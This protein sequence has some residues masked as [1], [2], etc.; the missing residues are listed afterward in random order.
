[1]C[2]ICHL[3]LD[4]FFASVEERDKE[5][6][7]GKPIVVGAD[8]NE[9]KGRGVVSTAN[10][11]AREYG[12]H[13]AMPIS[14]AWQLSETARKKGYPPAEFLGVDFARYSE[15]SERVMEII[16]KYSSK[17][18][19]A[20]ID[21]AY[22]EINSKSEIQNPKQIWEN[23]EKIAKSIKTEI[24]VKERITA[25]IGIGPNKLIAKIA[26]DFKKPDGLTIIQEEDAEKFLEPML[27]RKIPGI[28]PKTELLFS[29]K[30]IKTV[31]DLKRF[32]EAELYELLGKWGLE[33]YEKIHGRDD[34]PL[35]ESVE[36]KSIGE[37]ET[38]DKDTSDP[39]FIMSR[40]EALCQGV[41]SRFLTEGFTNF[42]TVV[43]TVRFADFETKSRARTF[44]KPPNDFKILYFEAMKMFMPF[45][46]GRENLKQKLIRLIGVRIEKL[47]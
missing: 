44:S 22:F 31:K 21:E 37:Q 27:I 2:I 15:T 38:F 3:D 46:D 43:I 36:A 17:I 35:I 9:G 40:L 28:G 32:S 6:L 19:Q 41:F 11:K 24:K 10:Y 26:S 42:R 45:L 14:K 12:I 1:M 18:E 13:S 8:P 33:L 30:G 5:W 4:A 16:R 20:S 34:S 47:V 7:R 29:K 39:A 25:S 23:A